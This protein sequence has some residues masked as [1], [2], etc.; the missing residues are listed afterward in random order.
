M[1]LRKL[2]VSISAL[3]LAAQLGS[4]VLA[5]EPTLEQLSR[6][7]EFLAGNDVDGLRDYIER[8]P[9]LLE[10]DSQMARLL[11]LFLQAA[12]DLPSSLAYPERATPA[13]PLEGEGSR[14]GDVAPG[15][16]RDTIY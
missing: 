4:P 16:G 10:G 13:D 8:N 14:M 2:S 6:I 9:E 15:A 1:N 11:E 3:V 12:D 5:A 7:E